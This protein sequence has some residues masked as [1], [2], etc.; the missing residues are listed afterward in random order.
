MIRRAL[1]W[2]DIPAWHIG[3]NVTVARLANPCWTLRSIRQGNLRLVRLQVGR[4][5]AVVSCS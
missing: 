4:L 2:D 5:A 3:R 1:V